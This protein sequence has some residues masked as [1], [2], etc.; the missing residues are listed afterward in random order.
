M[1]DQTAKSLTGCKVRA[2]SGRENGRRKEEGGM[3]QKG[4]LFFFCFCFLGE[5]ERWRRP[6]IFT[7]SFSRS[8]GGKKG[9]NREEERQRDE[10]SEEER[11]GEKVFGQLAGPQ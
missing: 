4:G 10:Q 11:G 6:R 7:V 5:G 1:R 8:K 2:R 3:R 9:R